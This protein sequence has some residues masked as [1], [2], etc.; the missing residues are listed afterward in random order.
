MCWIY[1]FFLTVIF[2]CR[3]PQGYLTNGNIVTLVA[4]TLYNHSNVTDATLIQFY[5]RVY[6][7]NTA[8]GRMWIIPVHLYMAGENP[9][10]ISLK[11]A[12]KHNWHYWLDTNH[13][14]PSLVSAMP[15][16]S[17][18]F[19]HGV[20]GSCAAV[21]FVWEN[22]A[23]GK[24]G[25]GETREHQKNDIYKTRDVQLP[26]TTLVPRAIKPRASHHIEDFY[27]SDY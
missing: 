6:N 11:L 1:W 19:P 24:C 13:V 7:I 18:P 22:G 8:L 12:R 16:R 10:G 17:L 15:L 5:S 9:A 21:C 27:L 2:K 26:C 20:C 25:T 14:N 4:V 23:N 3:N